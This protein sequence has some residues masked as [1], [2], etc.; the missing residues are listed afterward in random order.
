MP[1]AQVAFEFLDE[2]TETPYR[3]KYL[4]Q[5]RGPQLSRVERRKT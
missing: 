1:I 3:G 2:A 4:D 5:D